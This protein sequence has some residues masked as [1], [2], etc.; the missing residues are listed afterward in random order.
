MA[1]VFNIYAV[2][3]EDLFSWKK[4]TGAAKSYALPEERTSQKGM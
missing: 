1:A 4:V 2:K 3:T